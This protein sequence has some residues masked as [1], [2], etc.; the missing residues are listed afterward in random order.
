MMLLLDVLNAR[1]NRR[2]YI[3]ILYTYCLLILLA[4]EGTSET[5]PRAFVF[6]TVVE[7]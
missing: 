3:Y 5:I 2:L 4:R 6:A 7:S 1:N